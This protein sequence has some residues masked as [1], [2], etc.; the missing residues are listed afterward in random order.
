MTIKQALDWLEV[1]QKRHGP[2]TEVFFD[3]P[4]CDMSYT[5]TTVEAQAVH[6]RVEKKS[7]SERAEKGTQ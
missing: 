4:K 5:P 1:L 6:L 7:K 2:M 3:C